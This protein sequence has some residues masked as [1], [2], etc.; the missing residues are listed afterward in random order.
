MKPS[1]ALIGMPR[2]GTTWVAKAIDSHPD[3]LYLHEPDTVK[4]IASPIVIN[5]R[6]EVQYK[7]SIASFMAGLANERHSRCIGKLPLF[8]KNYRNVLQNKLQKLAVYGQKATEKA[9]LKLFEKK[10]PVFGELNRSTLFWK[11]I[12]SMGRAT[13][14]AANCPDSK[15]VILLR[16]PCAIYASVKRGLAKNKYSSSTPIYENWGLF[17]ELIKGEF[18]QKNN[19]TIEKLK[20]M[21]IAQRMAWRWLMFIE[22]T[23]QQTKNLANC[24]V[25]K[26]EDICANPTEYY[27]KICSFYGLSFDEQIKEYISETTSHSNDDFY[28]INKDPLVAS[29]K[30]KDELSR[31]E[32]ADITAVIENTASGKNYLNEYQGSAR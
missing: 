18:A 26:Y 23:E 15:F 14:L 11:S 2:S 3:V 4:K 7:E 17:E 5:K 10:M 19:I 32:I 30:W 31:E 28:A 25:I 29:Q 24:L 27:E 21:S 8:D 1:I 20:A 22:D 12:E 6:D 13:S 16:H 9:G